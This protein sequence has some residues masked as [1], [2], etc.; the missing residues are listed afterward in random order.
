MMSSES[1]IMIRPED[2]IVERYDICTSIDLATC[3]YN[4]RIKTITDWED[5]ETFLS[6]N[7]EGIVCLPLV[8]KNDEGVDLIFADGTQVRDKI[9]L[10]KDYI[11]EDDFEKKNSY[12]D[13]MKED[14]EAARV[15]GDVWEIAKDY[16]LQYAINI[17]QDELNIDPINYTIT[18]Y[19]LLTNKHKINVQSRRGRIY[20]W[21]GT[22]IRGLKSL[23]T[24]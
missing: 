3:V 1:E 18:M 21:T 22:A 8:K 9:K 14:N 20:S 13:K 12:M 4:W 5:A 23:V 16:F 17:P 24:N 2:T 15:S 19:H 10:L 11:K 6:F 7:D